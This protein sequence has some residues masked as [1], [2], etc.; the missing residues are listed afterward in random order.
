[1]AGRMKN[2]MQQRIALAKSR[3]QQMNLRLEHL[4]PQTKLG[5]N[6]MYLDELSDRMR[7]AMQHRLEQYQHR[8]ALLAEQLHR[9]SPTAKLIHGY[10][11]I[12]TGERPLCS[13]GQ[14]AAG[15]ELAIT[16]HDGQVRTMVT[17]VRPTGD[18][19]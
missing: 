19:E 3:W 15:D 6:Q 2:R 17:E 18:P 9:C 16:I 4:N 10:G 8:Y 7:R 14:I 12:E 11:Y 5:E 1:M 13:I